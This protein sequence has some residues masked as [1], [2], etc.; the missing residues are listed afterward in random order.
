L[1]KT[2]KKHMNNKKNKK[3]YCFYNFSTFL[4]LRESGHGGNSAH[5]VLVSGHPDESLES[6]VSSPAVLDNPVVISRSSIVSP[7]NGENSVV[8][9]GR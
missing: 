4:A 5:V 8:K 3:K 7:S 2:N 6:P 9:L 1:T